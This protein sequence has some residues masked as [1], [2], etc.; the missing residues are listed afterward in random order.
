MAYDRTN[1]D[2]HLTPRGWETGESPDDRVKTWNMSIDQASGWSKE[3]RSWTCEWVNEDM[4]R[5]KRG[6]LREKYRDR[7]GTPGRAG[8]IVTT[9][10]APL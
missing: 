8:N 3:Y 7:M 4:P 2:F 6:A 9:I 5:A 1:I 10:G